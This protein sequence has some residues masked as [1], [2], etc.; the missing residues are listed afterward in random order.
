MTAI[1]FYLHTNKGII[2]LVKVPN[3]NNNQQDQTTR[4]NSQYSAKQIFNQANCPAYSASFCLFKKYA[5]AQ[6]LGGVSDFIAYYSSV[7]TLLPLALSHPIL[8]F[9]IISSFLYHLF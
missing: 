8:N 3:S 2:Y 9:S 1:L 6:T 4:T 7:P 5:L